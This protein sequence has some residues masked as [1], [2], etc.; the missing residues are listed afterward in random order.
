MGT[1]LHIA[2]EHGSKFVIRT[3]LC[4][5]ADNTKRT[6]DGRTTVD[7]A[8]LNDSQAEAFSVVGW[9]GEGADPNPLALKKRLAP[10]ATITHSAGM[11][12]SDD[13][14]KWATDTANSGH[15]SNSDAGS[16]ASSGLAM[17]LMLAAVWFAILGMV[18]AVVI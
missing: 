16:P 6:D 15:T 14:H 4:A 17:P 8:K 7:F 18:A 12:A 2:A 5:R 9:P 13:A 11:P 1:T 3:L 10:G